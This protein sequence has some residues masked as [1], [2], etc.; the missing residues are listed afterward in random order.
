[1]VALAD[2]LLEIWRGEF[3]TVI[4]PS[5]C[6]KSTLLYILAGFEQ[7][8]DAQ[9]RATLQ[10]EVARLWAETGKTVLF[11]TH[12]VE[13]AVLLEDR[14]V[15]MTARPGR[16]KADVAVSLE[17][18]RDPT[19]PAFND[20]RRGIERLLAEASPT[21]SEENAEPA[22]ARGAGPLGFRDGKPHV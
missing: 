19:S 4:G 9:T 17:R 22:E 18:P 11:I 21:A 10:H 14:V 7:P 8:T 20:Y 6:G 5:G 15:I 16:I 3:V 12:S 2:I 13:E 1:M